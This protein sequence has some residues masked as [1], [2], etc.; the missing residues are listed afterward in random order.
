MAVVAMIMG[1]MAGF[2]AAIVAVIA[3]LPLLGALGI[4]SLGGAACAVLLLTRRPRP[5]PAQTARLASD[6]G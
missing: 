6:H 3:G 5:A 1:G 2:V 4:W